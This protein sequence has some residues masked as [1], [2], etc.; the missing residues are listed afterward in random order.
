MEHPLIGV[1]SIEIT[2]E[3]RPRREFAT[4]AYHQDGSMTVTTSGYA[5]HGAWLATNPRGARVR[6]LAPL[7]PAEGQ[8]GWQTVE[9]DV[10]VSPDGRMISMRGV[11]SR[12]TPSGV[13][14]RTAINGS[15]E[16]LLVSSSG[17]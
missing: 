11:H 17:S 15:G 14:T 1:W 12:P 10:E 9:M 13:S 2:F 8:P 6:A 7:G 5:A 16:R 3:G 4:S